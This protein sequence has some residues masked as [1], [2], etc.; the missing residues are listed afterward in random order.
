MTNIL[1]KDLKENIEEYIYLDGFM[2]CNQCSTF[3]PSQDNNQFINKPWG[4]FVGEKGCKYVGM[5]F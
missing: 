4:L 5:N 2:T 3:L 1:A